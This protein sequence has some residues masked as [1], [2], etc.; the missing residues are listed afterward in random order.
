MVMIDEYPYK[1][2]IL[3]LTEILITALRKLINSLRDKRSI[4]ITGMFN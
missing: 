3:F 1:K 4:A 2:V